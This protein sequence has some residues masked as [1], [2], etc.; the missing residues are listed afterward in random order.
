MYACIRAACTNHPYLLSCQARECTVQ[1]F[2]NRD[3][4]RLDLPAA[5]ISAVIGDG[6]FNPAHNTLD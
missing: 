2:F 5:I 4:I 1:H 3:A 6:K